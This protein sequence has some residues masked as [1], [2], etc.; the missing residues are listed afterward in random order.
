MNEFSSEVDAL[1][2]WKNGPLFIMSS[3]CECWYMFIIQHTILS[4]RFSNDFC[5]N[6]AEVLNIL[7]ESVVFLLK[8]SQSCLFCCWKVSSFIQLFVI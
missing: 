6:V 7:Q 4:K 2:Q 1:K 8:Y 3:V 5:C